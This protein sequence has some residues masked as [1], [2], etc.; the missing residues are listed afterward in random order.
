MSLGV[1]ATKVKTMV[2]VISAIYSAVAGSLYAH[3]VTHVSPSVFEPWFSVMIVTMATIGGMRS[4]WGG[5][6]G[7][8][9]YVGMREV[10]TLITQELVPGASAEYE[11]IVFALLFLIILRFAPQG[12]VQLPSVIRKRMAG[13][14]NGVNPC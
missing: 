14:S 12:L 11:V 6:I 10:I 9:F 13:S 4:I 7:A 1:D 2:F 8:A 5:V 3:Y